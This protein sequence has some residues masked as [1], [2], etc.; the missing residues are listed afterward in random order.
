MRFAFHRDVALGRFVP[1]DTPIHRLDPRAKLGAFALLLI[2]IFRAELPA[3]LGLFGLSLALAMWARLAPGRILGGLRAAS[4]ILALT[5]AFHALWIGPRSIGGVQAG[6]EQG[7]LAVIRLVAMLVL[8]ALLTHAT[9][10]IRLADGVARLFGFLERVRVPVQDLALVLTLA[11]RFLPTVLE[12]A[13]RIVLA[14]R[15]RGARFE[16]GLLDRGRRLLP[17]AVPLFAGCLHRA[18]RLALAMD[19]RGYSTANERTQLEPLAFRVADA[20]TLLG[21]A[22]V[23]TASVYLAK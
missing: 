6:V 1:L 23:L 22:L 13:D 4:W 19:A 11:L 3:A 5:F 17:L 20:W 12:E 21:A 7:L 2:A 14:Q 16:G 10:P 8:S 15:A 18:D 9:E